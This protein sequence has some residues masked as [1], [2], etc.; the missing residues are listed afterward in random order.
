MLHGSYLLTIVIFF[1]AAASLRCFSSA[2]TI[3]FGFAASR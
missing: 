2:P 3:T 1:P